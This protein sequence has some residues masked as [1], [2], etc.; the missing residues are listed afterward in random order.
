M[1][2]SPSPAGN[3]LFANGGESSDEPRLGVAS[4][5]AGIGGFDLGFDVSLELFGDRDVE[6]SHRHAVII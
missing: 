1:K 3:G 6:G 2:A 4:F 5:F